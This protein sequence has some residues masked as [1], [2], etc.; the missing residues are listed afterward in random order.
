MR[1]RLDAGICKKKS[2]CRSEGRPN[3]CAAEAFQVEWNTREGIPITR[4]LDTM[5]R[6]G[7]AT[8]TPVRGSSARH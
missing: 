2:L 3:G 6:P 8:L 4:D 5:D 7:L 1:L